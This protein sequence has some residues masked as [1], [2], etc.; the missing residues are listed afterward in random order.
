[1]FEKIFDKLG[2]SY[3]NEENYLRDGKIYDAYYLLKSR[4]EKE[5][6]FLSGI[7]LIIMNKRKKGI[8]LMLEYY[9]G[10]K[11]IVEEDI[12]NELIGTA[13]Y[14]EENYLEASRYYIKSLEI[15]PNNTYSKYN[16][17]NVALVKKDY[18][19]AYKLL[20]ELIKSEPNNNEILEKLKFVE[21]KINKI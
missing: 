3:N 1:M 9:E 7:L 6:Q 5:A 12:I 10:G 20:Q 8:D 2:S 16:L 21:E 11:K 4:K 13:F 19:H 17:I 14:Q 18:R 15:N